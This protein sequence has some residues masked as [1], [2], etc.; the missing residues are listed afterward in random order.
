MTIYVQ[1]NPDD[2]IFPYIC[3]GDNR[4]NDVATHFIPFYTDHLDTKQY[5]LA[6]QIDGN[7][8]LYKYIGSQLQNIPLWSSQTNG[9]APY[10]C[11]MQRDGNLV[12]YGFTKQGFQALWASNTS[13][14]PG[15]FL[16]VQNDGNVV[17]YAADRVTALWSTNTAGQ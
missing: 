16:V 2:Q 4:S 10:N 7:L 3:P 1:M 12:L 8:V 13:G 9:Q 17:I 15:A 5:R 11:V 14:N 6:L